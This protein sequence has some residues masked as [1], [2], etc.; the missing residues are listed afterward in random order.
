MPV[1]RPHCNITEI[2]TAGRSNQ[3][4]AELLRNL[5]WLFCS[6]TADGYYKQLNNRFLSSLVHS[7]LFG[8]LSSTTEKAKARGFRNG[9]AR[10]LGPTHPQY[11]LTLVPFDT[12]G[13]MCSFQSAPAC[14]MATIVGSK[15][16]FTDNNKNNR[17]HYQGIKALDNM[18]ARDNP[19]T[20]I[21]PVSLRI[22]QVMSP[23]P[24]TFE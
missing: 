10:F 8:P 22:Q 16:H 2:C 6:T 23:H 4:Q 7:S 9:T 20:P 13:S 24:P 17:G 3:G 14:E 18:Y 11:P 19:R 12:K 5:W 1:F 21:R 15:D